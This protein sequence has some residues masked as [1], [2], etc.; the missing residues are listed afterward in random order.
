MRYIKDRKRVKGVCTWCAGPVKAPKRFWCSPD[1]IHEFLIRTSGKYL[2]EKTFERDKG[3]CAR[4][5]KDCHADWLKLKR[6][7]NQY[8][9]TYFAKHPSEF[10][11]NQYWEL[12]CS[13]GVKLPKNP[14]AWLVRHRPR[15]LWDA[16]HIKAVEEGGGGCGLENIQTLCK[17]CHHIK[18]AKHTKRRARR[19]KI[20]SRR[21][22]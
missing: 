2:R 1:C 14:S 5:N 13:Y 16:D 15:S 11:L 8:L 21:T 9:Q 10:L 17:S 4:C 7:R 6:L 18:T 12:A 19:K 3:F 22:K 20:E